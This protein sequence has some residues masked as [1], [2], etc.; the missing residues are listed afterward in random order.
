MQENNFKMVSSSG[1]VLTHER[2]AK[3]GHCQLY[4]TS[5]QIVLA[6]VVPC[7]E[8]NLQDKC[9]PKLDDFKTFNEGF[10]MLEP[11]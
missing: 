6:S 8:E 1:V 4:E 3:S 10:V 9:Q 11:F 5:P 2:L 7:F